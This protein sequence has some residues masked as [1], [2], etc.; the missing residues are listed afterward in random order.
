MDAVFCAEREGALLVL[1]GALVGKRGVL[2]ARA[3]RGW[4][5]RRI[6]GDLSRVVRRGKG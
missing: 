3:E 4:E 2:K 5:E 6:G 1:V